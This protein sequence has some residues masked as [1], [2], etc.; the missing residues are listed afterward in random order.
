M[1]VTLEAQ[2]EYGST[3]TDIEKQCLA[4]LITTSGNVEDEYKAFVEQWELEG[5]LEYETEATEYY[6]NMNK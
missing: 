1:P 6:S 2:N 3:L 5:G 4:S